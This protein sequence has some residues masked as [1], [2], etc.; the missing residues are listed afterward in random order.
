MQL[1]DSRVVDVWSGVEARVD[2]A[3][4]SMSVM[5]IALGVNMKHRRAPMLGA[6][7]LYEVKLMQKIQVVEK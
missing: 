2:E 7:L 1:T 3:S 5:M 4:L 6:P